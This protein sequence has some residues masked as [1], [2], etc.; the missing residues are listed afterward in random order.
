MIQDTRRPTPGIRLAQNGCAFLVLAASFW[1]ATAPAQ[2]YPRDLYQPFPPGYGYM[3]ENDALQ[4]AI[5]KGDTA[6][7]REHGWKLFAGIMQPAKGMPSAEGPAWPVWMTW[8]NSYF[9]FLEKSTES[10]ETAPMTVKQRNLANTPDV[11][12][13]R[14]PNYPAPQGY[15][16]GPTFVANGDVMIATESLSIEAYDAIRDPNAPLYQAE[17]LDALHGKLV[18]S[19]SSPAQSIDLPTASIVTKHM[20]WPVMQDGVSPLPV[21]DPEQF[22]DPNGFGGFT[23]AYSGYE[24]WTKF[25]AIDPTGRSTGQTVK[26]TFQAHADLS[27]GTDLVPIDAEA[28]VHGIDEFYYKQI[29]AE[30]WAKFTDADRMIVNQASLWAF[31]RPF[32]VN[33]YL[34]TIAMHVVT[35]EVPYWAFQTVWWSDQAASGPYSENRPQ[36]PSGTFGPWDRYLMAVEYG[37]PVDAPSLPVAMNPYIEPVIHPLATNCRNCH[38]RAGWPSTSNTASNIPADMPRTSYQNQACRDLLINL[39]PEGECFNGILKSD[40]FWIIPDRAK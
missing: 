14:T 2:D 16:D 34:V 18:P 7:I 10:A 15:G 28:A 40:F 27:K 19:P 20:Y 37:V 29:T 8:P 38:V 35:K 33:D 4:T 12:F 22:R 11:N 13:D 30:D 25:V 3:E 9:A 6:T 36:M 26:V 5:D 23:T 31:G 39:K 24:T 32:R 1:P 17:Y 21:W